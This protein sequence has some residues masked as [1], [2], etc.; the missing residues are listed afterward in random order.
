[1]QLSIR[2]S[3]RELTYDLQS[4]VPEDAINVREGDTSS[5]VGAIVK[6]SLN[7]PRSPLNTFAFVQINGAAEVAPDGDKVAADG[8]APAAPRMS[9]H[10]LDP[11]EKLTVRLTPDHSRLI[12]SLILAVPHIVL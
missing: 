11:L 2:H 9:Y 7:L 10:D 3:G 8:L 6:I 5:E 12:L 1:M 4:V